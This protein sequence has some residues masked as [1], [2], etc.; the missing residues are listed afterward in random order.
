MKI[1]QTWTETLT[2]TTS[3]IYT[4]IIATKYLFLSAYFKAK[5]IFTFKE[6]DQNQKN[7]N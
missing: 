7:S 4:T 1:N 2:Y 6:Y 3:S 5:H